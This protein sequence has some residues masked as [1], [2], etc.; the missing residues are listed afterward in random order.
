MIGHQLALLQREL[1]EHRSIYVTPAAIASVVLVLTLTGQV[2][3]SAFGEGVDMAIV[4][5]SNV[6]DVHRRMAL[7][8]ILGFVTSIFALG[9]LIVTIF[10]CLD[11]LYAERK[12]KSILFWRS[13]PIT[14]AETVISKLITAILVIPLVALIAAIATQLLVLML[15]SIWVIIQGGNAGHLIWA[16]APLA[17]MWIS[18][19]IVALA[20]PLWLSPFIGWFLFVSAYTKRSPLLLAFLPIFIVPMLEAMLP[21]RS[22]LLFNAIFVRTFKVP[23]FNVD[24]FSWFGDDMRFSMAEE[25]IS[26]LGSLDLTKF[27]GSPSLWAG[28]IVCGLF[29]TAAIY[30]RRYR[31]ESY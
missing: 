31:D 1:W 4:G 5:A 26:M 14:D 10:Y 13:L 21:G 19:L 17:D 30:V 12:D 24:E 6:D 25:T 9:A 8:G 23:L 15:S 11:T 2:T 16:S 29:T 3:V 18:S 27:L 7:G 22:H 28:L 20:M